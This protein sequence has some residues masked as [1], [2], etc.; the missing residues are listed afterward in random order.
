MAYDFLKTPETNFCNIC[1]GEHYHPDNATR[2]RQVRLA[3]KIS[4]EPNLELP[5]NCAGNSRE[6]LCKY[7]G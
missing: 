4:N 6:C 5:N 7:A 3:M 1:R 2:Q